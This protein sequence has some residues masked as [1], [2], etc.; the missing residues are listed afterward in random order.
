MIVAVPLFGE[1]VSPRFGYANEMML[2][3]VD[4][5]KV[6]SV[7]R[8]AVPG[9]GGMQ[10]CSLILS[11]RPDAVV[12]GGIHPRWQRMLEHQ[13]ITVLGGVIGRAEDAL[14]SYAAGNL[15]SD[16]FV[17]PRRHGG[18]GRRQGRRGCQ[19]N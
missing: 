11:V 2:A 8:L 6:E 4:S 1:E 13:R 17:C 5:G 18:R 19:R 12:C 16:Q 14:G 10:V 3:D 15:K 7:R 9:G